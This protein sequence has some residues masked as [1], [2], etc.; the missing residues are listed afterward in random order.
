MRG[1]LPFVTLILLVVSS[2][3][4]DH[5]LP[6]VEPK[7]VGLSDKVLDELQP[8][9][10]KLIAD[11]EIAGAV[12]VVGRHGKLARV[13]AVGCRDLASKAP[14]TEDTIFA[15]ASMTKPITCIAAMQLVEEGKLSLDDPVEKFVPAFRN[16]RVLGDVKD[17]TAA[18][19]ATIP[20]KRTMLVRHLFAHTSGLS[21]GFAITGSETEQRM[22]RAYSKANLSAARLKTISE[23]PAELARLPLAH[24]PGENWTYGLSHDVL[25]Y[26]I[27]VV[28]G[29]T[30]NQFLRDRIFAPLDMRDTSFLVPESSRDRVATIYTTTGAAA[31]P[32]TALPRTFG[33]ATYFSGGGGLFSTARDYSRFSQM[34]LSGGEFEGKR[35]VKRDTLALMTSNQIGDQMV[36]GV[37][38][39][40]LGFGMMMSQP[41]PGAPEPA[42]DFYGWA[43]A[44]STSFWVDPRRDI[45]GVVMTQVMPVSQS[46]QFVH[47]AVNKSVEN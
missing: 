11:N 9:L 22:I 25:G 13:E 17:D 5:E 20:V 28:T 21:Y 19:L 38:K 44:Y 16:L 18:V 29:Q 33:S 34:L 26:V 8:G 30:L 32:L 4:P 42:L 47:Q 35:L 41:T 46:T 45:F 40:G 39:Y 15:I 24:E 27:E 12:V 14:M 6:R 2:G 31:G 10:A 3:I 23:L 1:I 43:G 37:M 36:F 7:V